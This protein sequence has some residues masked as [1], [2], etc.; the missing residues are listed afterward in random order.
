MASSSSDP[1]NNIPQAFKDLFEWNPPRLRSIPGHKMSTKT[2]E[3]AF[4]VKHFSDNL[5]LLHMKRMPSLVD[6]IAALVDK[7]IPDYPDNVLSPSPA[8]FSAAFVGC[9]MD[10]VDPDMADEKSV[11]RFYDH[12]TAMFDP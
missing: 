5:K 10:Q 3:P 8:W 6:D 2:R 11:A 7:T 12:T 9:I 1:L 4:F